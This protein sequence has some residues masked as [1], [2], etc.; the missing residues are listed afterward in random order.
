MAADH[1]TQEQ[2]LQALVTLLTESDLKLQAVIRVTDR[3]VFVDGGMALS[4]KAMEK[5]ELFNFSFG[6]SLIIGDQPNAVLVAWGTYPSTATPMPY[7]ALL[8]TMYSA[9]NSTGVIFL[10]QMVKRGE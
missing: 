10:Y 1:P 3:G 9:D 4:R 2:D 7:P 6:G 8:L 5:G